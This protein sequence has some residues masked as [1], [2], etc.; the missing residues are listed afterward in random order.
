MTN[1]DLNAVVL[2]HGVFFK[3]ASKDHLHIECNWCDSKNYVFYSGLRYRTS[4]S[5]WIVKAV[6]HMVE[7]HQ[8]EIEKYS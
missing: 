7:N 8:N 5:D 3:V 4:S 2:T 6:T 1:L